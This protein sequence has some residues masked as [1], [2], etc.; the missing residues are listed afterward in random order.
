MPGLRW[1]KEGNMDITG[2]FFSWRNENYVLGIVVIIGTCSVCGTIQ[3]LHVG[4]FQYAPLI[5]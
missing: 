1:I 3:F 5:S 4:I 2:V